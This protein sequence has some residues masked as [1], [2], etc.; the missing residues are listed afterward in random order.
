MIGLTRNDIMHA[1]SEG[2]KL[3]IVD[4]RN[5]EIWPKGNARL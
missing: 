3:V 4:P 1:V 2:C 5:I